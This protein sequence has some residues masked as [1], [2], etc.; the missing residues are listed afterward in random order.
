MEINTTWTA[1]QE[2]CEPAGPPFAIKTPPKAEQN[3]VDVMLMCIFWK[4]PEG[5]DDAWFVNPIR[6]IE[7]SHTK[8][9]PKIC[10]PPTTCQGRSA[11]SR[12]T[13]EEM[14]LYRRHTTLSRL[15]IRF[16]VRSTVHNRSRS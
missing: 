8:L 6:N 12:G 3:H 7:M 5:D 9:G 1:E 10:D 14:Q 11:V 15:G 16:G 2:H 4:A 13:M